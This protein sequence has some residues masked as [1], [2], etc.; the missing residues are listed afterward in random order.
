M[1]NLIKP[2]I[3]TIVCV[4]AFVCVVL[5]YNSLSSSYT[6]QSTNNPTQQNNNNADYTAPDFE[7]VDKDG[8]AVSLSQFKN[9]AV[10]INYWASWCGP[11]KAEMPYFEQAYKD[12][13]DVQF[14]MLNSTMDDSKEAADEFIKD[15]GYTFPVFYDTTGQFA[16]L[17]GI[18]SYPT[19]FFID[20]Q[21]Q[22]Y[23]YARGAMTKD[24]LYSNI[25]M[26]R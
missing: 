23:T 17:Y 11:C 2:L 16:Y 18:S 26:I 15:R 21:G 6:P 24:T 4:I 7:M 8:N 19:T 9:K 13:E 14:V 1:K 12:F 25:E 20:K 10:V 22:L 3:I 5:L